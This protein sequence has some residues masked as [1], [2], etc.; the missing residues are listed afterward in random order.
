MARDVRYLR[1]F[2]DQYLLTNK[3]GQWFVGHIID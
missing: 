1:G 2:R 3:L